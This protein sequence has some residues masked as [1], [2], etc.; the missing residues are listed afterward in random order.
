MQWRGRARRWPCPPIIG[1]FFLVACCDALLFSGA[2]QPGEELTR[3]P[4]SHSDRLSAATTRKENPISERKEASPDDVVCYLLRVARQYSIT[5]LANTSL[6]LQSAMA[7]KGLAGKTCAVVSS[8]GVMKQLR[9]ADKID[10]ADVVMRFNW[11]PVK[12]Y[13]QYVGHKDMVRFVNMH[14]PKIVKEGLYEPDPNVIYVRTLLG[15][16]GGTKSMDLWSQ[17]AQERPDL[18]LFAAQGALG[19]ERDVSAALHEMFESSEFEGVR[20]WPTS[21]AVGMVMA[22]EVCKQV[23]A[24]GM[25]MVMNAE[26][27]QKLSYHY[28]EEGGDASSNSWHKSFAAEKELWRYIAQNN[29]EIDFSGRGLGSVEATDA[30]LIN[31]PA[32]CPVS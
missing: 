23:E 9:A 28:Y 21:G 7:S 18:Q 8:S 5:S 1:F 4:E 32:T 19:L 12:G 3:L 17:F 26:K 2:P 24:F 14:F 20:D 29:Q 10:A 22:L 15:S 11:A 30:A 16:G 25:P 27:G 31:V 6:T 13:E